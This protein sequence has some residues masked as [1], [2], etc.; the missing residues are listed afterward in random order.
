MK[1]RFERELGGKWK[2]V[3]RVGTKKV[4][5]AR[6]GNGCE[7]RRVHHER[8]DVPRGIQYVEVRANCVGPQFCSIE[9]ML[10]MKGIMKEKEDEK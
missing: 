8:P 2:R 10:Y 9:C 6:T 7:D 4:A 3:Y 5:C 1:I